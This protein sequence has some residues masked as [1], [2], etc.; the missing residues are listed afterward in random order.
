VGPGTVTVHANEVAYTLETFK[1]A[2][3][4]AGF[5]DFEYLRLVMKED[6]E[7]NIKVEWADFL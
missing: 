2:F 1:K 7:E 5:K 4:E 6:A 3:E